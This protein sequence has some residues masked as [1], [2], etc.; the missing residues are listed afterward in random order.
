MKN[1]IEYRGFI[2][3]VEIDE[4]GQGFG[5]KLLGTND[6]VC[7]Y[8]GDTYKE[9]IKMFHQTVDD[10]IADNSINEKEYNQFKGSFNVRV[11][12]KVHKDAT[13]YAMDKHISLNKLVEIA[14]REKIYE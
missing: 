1:T 9:F 7:I 12:P 11:N 2:G 6:D 3:T 10:Y 13:I 4:D 8:M 14:I 5:G